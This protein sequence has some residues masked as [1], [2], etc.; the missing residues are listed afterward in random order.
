MAKKR[1]RPRFNKNTLNLFPEEEIIEHSYWGDP[2]P[3][4]IKYVSEYGFVVHG[5][6]KYPWLKDLVKHHEGW[7][8][9]RTMVSLINRG[10]YKT[11]ELDPT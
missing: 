5:S 10:Y 9:M 7:V 1:I 4:T 2:Q 6:R 11:S 8:P 3:L